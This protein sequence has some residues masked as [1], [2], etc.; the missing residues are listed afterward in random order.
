MENIPFALVESQDRSDISVVLISPFMRTHVHF[1]CLDQKSG[2]LWL[3]RIIMCQYAPVRSMD[4]I[5][6]PGLM[7]MIIAGSSFLGIISV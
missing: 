5:Q 4:G 3:G 6:L 1:R 7:I 2:L